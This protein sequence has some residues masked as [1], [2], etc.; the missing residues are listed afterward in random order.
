LRVS[1]FPLTNPSIQ[2]FYPL[3]AAF[4]L[5]GYFSS[6]EAEKGKR[7]FLKWAGKGFGFGLLLVLS[8]KSN[9]INLNGRSK[10]DLNRLPGD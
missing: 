8:S 3:L 6:R 2:A 7:K 1:P 4:P 9:F 5:S 10:I